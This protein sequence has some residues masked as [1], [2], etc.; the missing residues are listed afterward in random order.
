MDADLVMSLAKL[1]M[2]CSPCNVAEVLRHLGQAANGLANQR[3]QTLQITSSSSLWA[4]VDAVGLRRACSHILET[5]LQ[6]TPKG[7]YVRTDAMPAPG[8]GVLI[9]IEDNGPDIVVLIRFP[10]L[11]CFLSGVAITIR[12][13]SVWRVIVPIEDHS[14]HPHQLHFVVIFILLHIAVDENQT[15][16]EN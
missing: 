1:C 3:G 16:L 10:I 14:M 13:H 12:H 15:D 4:A 7:G 8:G 6:H 5:A 9:I 11:H 2:A